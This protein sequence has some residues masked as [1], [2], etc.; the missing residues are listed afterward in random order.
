MQSSGL[1]I[2]R[3]AMGTTKPV[4]AKDSIE[5]NPNDSLGGM[6]ERTRNQFIY[7]ERSWAGPMN[8]TDIERVNIRPRKPS[9]SYWIEKISAIR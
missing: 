4:T 6:A 7:S 9:Y 1:A 2:N 5:K 8:E 3:E